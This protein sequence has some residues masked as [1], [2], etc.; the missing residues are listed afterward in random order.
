MF[1]GIVYRPG[2]KCGPG[3]IRAAYPH[4]CRTYK[5]HSFSL[6]EVVSLL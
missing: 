6:L 1:Q 4:L 5:L 3:R 2:T